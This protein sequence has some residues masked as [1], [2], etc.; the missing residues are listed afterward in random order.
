LQSTGKYHPDY[1][2]SLNNQAHIFSELGDNERALILADSV[3]LFRKF[4][5]G[6]NH[7]E[8]LSILSNVAVYEYLNGN[9]S[10]AYSYFDKNLKSIRSSVFL[11]HLQEF[12]P[13][14]IVDMSFQKRYK[15]LC[16]FNGVTT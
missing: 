10:R 9:Y 3:L 5:W 6:E 11:R 13:I 1:F 12:H 4:F 15:R 8:Y 14:K 16:S 7:P 2:I